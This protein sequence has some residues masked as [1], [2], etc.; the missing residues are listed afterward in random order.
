MVRLIAPNGVEV[1]ASDQ[2]APILLANGYK[3]AKAP[4]KPRKKV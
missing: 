1:N 4:R 3:K 2:D